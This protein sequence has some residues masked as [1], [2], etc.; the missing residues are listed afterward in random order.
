[1][2]LGCGDDQQETPVDAGA[3]APGIDA[4]GDPL[5]PAE[6]AAMKLLSP[7]PAVP[8]DSTNQFANNVK[9]ATLGQMLFFDKSYSGAL[10]VADDGTNGGL[11]AAGSVGKVSCASCHAAGSDGMD[12][13]RTRPNNVS[14]GTDYGTRNALAVVNSSFY[15]WT[16]WAGRFDSQW[17]LPLAVAENAKIMKST[18]LEIAHMLYAK[19]RTEYNATFPVALDS[20]LDPTATDAARF[21]AVGKPKA[22][23]ADP[24]GPWEGMTQADRDIVNTIFANYGKAL[25]AYMRTLVSRDAPFDRFVSGDRAA[26]SPAAVNGLKIFLASCVR[27]HSGPNFADDKFHALGVA[28][29]GPRVPAADLG[30]FQDVPGLLGSPF[31]S[32]G[33]FSDDKLTGRLTNLTQQAAQTGQFR[34]KSLRNVAQSAPFMHSG[35][36]AT[37]A[38]VVA[39]YNTGGGTPPAGITKD[40]LLQPLALSPQQQADL[41]AFLETL[42]GADVSAELVTDTS[43]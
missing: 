33:N 39:F 35:Q 19:Y 18:R 7:L 28:Q 5:T 8:A 27:C 41:V 31:N 17:S 42:T 26:I 38:D 10:A 36:H 6:I 34:T 3:D 29:T 9:A 40:P 30:R 2:L 32:N 14:L 23:A 1:M 4:P 13:R 24:D 20:A 21:P 11:G 12:D 25:Q 16:N 37:L 43:K 15:A 22:A